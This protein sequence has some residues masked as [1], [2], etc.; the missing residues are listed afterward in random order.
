MSLALAIY[1]EAQASVRACGVPRCSSAVVGTIRVRFPDGSAHT[2]DTCEAHRAQA[3]RDGLVVDTPRVVP[4]APSPLVSDAPV[5]RSPSHVPVPEAPRRARG[6]SG[7]AEVAGRSTRRGA[8]SRAQPSEAVTATSGEGSEVAPAA[9]APSAPSPGD[10][11]ALPVEDAEALGELPSSPAQAAIPDASPSTTAATLPVAVVEGRDPSSRGPEHL[12]ESGAPAAETA[13]RAEQA[14]APSPV[15]C[16]DCGRRRKPGVFGHYP[17][18]CPCKEPTMAAPVNRSPE[19]HLRPDAD[20]H[21]ELCRVEGCESG[22]IARGVCPRH[23]GQLRPFRR[24]AE[25]AG[26]ILLPPQ[27]GPRAS[28]P[29][30]GHDE[31]APT[32]E[33]TERDRLAQ[34]V[35][36]LEA[37]LG[38]LTDERQALTT[39]RAQLLLR[40][41]G[42]ER[43]V[44]EIQE[45]F[46]RLRQHVA[47]IDA[48]LNGAAVP[49]VAVEPCGERGGM[50]RLVAL[51]LVV[52]EAL[53]GARL[54]RLNWLVGRV[55]TLEQL[56]PAVTRATLLQAAELVRDLNQAEN[57]AAT[58]RARLAA[59][60]LEVSLG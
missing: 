41:E 54:Q 33:E 19:P 34:R 58:A 59:L 35:A 17:R 15:P 28:G 12:V 5:R 52:D 50:E 46:A 3:I 10:G 47:E 27:S 22:P 9:P 16:P 48:A 13:P 40:A 51:G 49:L 24:W 30:Q 36:E 37:D 2:V 18:P 44:V 57:A 25:K 20:A 11:R 7:E 60:D 43:Q 1:G 21:P 53:P 8:P 45:A 6:H 14:P 23:H 55:R 39:E 31:P 26:M 4:S 38:A 29:I 42:A 32:V 56:R